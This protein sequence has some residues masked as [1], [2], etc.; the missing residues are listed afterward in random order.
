[1]PISIE[2]DFM[3]P[4][5][6]SM[7]SL[8]SMTVSSPNIDR[9]VEDAVHLAFKAAEHSLGADAV[10][11]SCVEM[12]IS[13]STPATYADMCARI[14]ASLMATMLG[15]ED[16]HVLV[17]DDFNAPELAARVAFW[18][19]LKKRLFIIEKR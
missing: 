2:V 12:K 11:A 10:R 19:S 4:D 5:Y 7:G 1:M 17:K 6:M 16:G 9:I 8:F 14:K 15:I 3:M 18:N 13:G